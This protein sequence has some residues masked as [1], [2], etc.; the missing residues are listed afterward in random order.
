MARDSYFKVIL[1]I[2]AAALT[3][4]AFAQVRQILAPEVVAGPVKPGIQKVV[5]CDESG[6]FCARVDETSRLF[7]K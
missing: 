7:V 3:V 4:I 6:D 1:T 5:I 2:I